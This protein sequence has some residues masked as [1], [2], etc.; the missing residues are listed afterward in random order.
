[1]PDGTEEQIAADVAKAK[2]EA[3]ASKKPDSPKT[4]PDDEVK[5]IIEDRD[6]AKHLLRSID[7][8]NKKSEEQ[9]AIEEGK[10]KEV[11]AKREAELV[12]ALNKAQAFED[13]QKALRDG[14][15]SKIT[16]PK[17]KSIAEELSIA[18]L[19]EFTESINTDK[20]NPFSAKGKPTEGNKSDFERRDKESWPE[21]QARVQK[22]RD[23]KRR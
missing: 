15:L 10:L 4:W 2:A 19:Q 21:Y 8:A 9:K 5:K 17:L 7:E 13:Q 12:E 18:K 3:E 23:S 6:K 22:L 11:L 14:L 20:G 16:D 1:M